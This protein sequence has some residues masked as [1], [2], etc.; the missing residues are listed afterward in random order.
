MQGQGRYKCHVIYHA[1]V[2][3]D[4][5]GHSATLSLNSIGIRVDDWNGRAL[6]RRN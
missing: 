1:L 2:Q 6:Y 4:Q 5:M 3:P